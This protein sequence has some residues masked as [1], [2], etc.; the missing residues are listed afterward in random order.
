MTIANLSLIV[1]FL[2]L[3]GVYYVAK[4]LD[5]KFTRLSE[6]LDGLARR[7]DKLEG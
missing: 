1:G 6:R 3:A 4:E 7:L 2:G 5:T